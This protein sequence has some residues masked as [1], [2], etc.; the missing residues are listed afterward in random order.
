[1]TIGEGIKLETIK[2]AKLFYVD[3]ILVV[4]ETKL[5]LQKQLKIIGNY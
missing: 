1:M 4:S 3:D 2:I 5:G